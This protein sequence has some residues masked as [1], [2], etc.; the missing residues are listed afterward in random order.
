MMMD[1]VIFGTIVMLVLIFIYRYYTAHY[2]NRWEV[3]KLLKDAVDYGENTNLQE[4]H[5]YD[6]HDMLGTNRKYE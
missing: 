3:A 1:F 5:I 4:Q 6:I 2:T